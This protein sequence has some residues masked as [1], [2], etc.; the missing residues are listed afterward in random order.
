MCSCLSPS[1]VH[2]D[3][4]DDNIFIQQDFLNAD[5]TF[6]DDDE[7]SLKNKGKKGIRFPAHII[8]FSD[9]LIGEILM[10]SISSKK[11]IFS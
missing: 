8:D 11:K 2:A 10:E 7:I 5:V 3:V 6:D 4:M 1:W 9:L